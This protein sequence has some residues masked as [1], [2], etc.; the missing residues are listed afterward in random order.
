MW[1]H[2][3]CELKSIEVGRS[4]RDDNPYASLLTAS[5]SL[6]FSSLCLVSFPPHVSCSTK[7]QTEAV[8]V[9]QVRGC[10]LEL[11]K[12]CKSALETLIPNMCPKDM[13]LDLLPNVPACSF[14]ALV[15]SVSSMQCSV[16]LLLHVR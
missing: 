7:F 11:Q 13:V 14:N 12:G 9:L 8:S 10:K 2:T 5:P 16:D 4:K 6:A 15:S 3:S 1:T